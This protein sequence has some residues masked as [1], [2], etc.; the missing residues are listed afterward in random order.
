MA[1]L[2]FNSTHSAVMAFN[3]LRK[4][5]A[6]CVI[7]HMGKKPIHKNWQHDYYTDPEGAEAFKDNNIGFV[8]GVAGHY[9]I[10]IDL[11]CPEAIKLAPSFLS[12]TPWVFGHKSAPRSHYMYRCNDAKTIKFSSPL[13][14]QTEGMVIE[15]RAQG[16]QTVAPGSTHPSDEPVRFETSKWE[17]ELPTQI[18]SVQLESQCNDLAAASLILRHG[19]QAGKRDEVAVALCG[20][21]LR[22]G[23]SV[24]QVDHFLSAIA[25]AAGDEELDMRLKAE[26]QAER[27]ANNEKVPGIPSLIKH[28]GTDLANT[29]VA[30]LG[31]NSL[32][33]IHELNA[34]IA[35]VSMGGKS[36]I[37]IDGG[38]LSNG[39]F[40][41]MN[42]NDARTM[43]ANRG[44]VKLGKRKI[45][46]FDYWI[47]SPERRTYSRL[48][49]NPAGCHESE[50]NF[51]QG[52]PITGINNPAGCKLFLYHVRTV[53][54]DGDEDL[55]DYL[56]NWLADAIQNP[57]RKPGVALVM[58][59][60]EEGTGKTMFARYV[61][62]MFGQYG[63]VSTNSDHLFGKHNFH[64]ARKL[65]VFAD[66]SV[67]AGNHHHKAML[68]NLITGDSLSFEPKGVDSFNLDNHVR[69]MMATNSDWAVP[70]GGLARRFCVTQVSNERLRDWNYFS[71]LEY[72]ELHD[73]PECL[74]H[75]LMTYQLTR[76]LNEVPITGA[77]M[78]NK[79]LTMERDNP[80][81]AWWYQRLK[82]GTSTRHCDRWELIV[83]VKSLY[84][85]YVAYLNRTVPG[86]S[87]ET[88][89][90]INLKR[91]VPAMGICMRRASGIKP[92][93]T[94]AQ[95]SQPRARMRCY[96]VPKLDECRRFF[97]ENIMRGIVEWE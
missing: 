52:W 14:G 15:L 37:I 64:L 61:L 54:C 75:Y 18:E 32:N 12:P 24:D 9:A 10:D 74:F 94:S 22:S 66:E 51:W 5:F 76:N 4:G 23:R 17:K 29:I 46:K 63:S 26:Y 57:T 44:E 73:G 83:P 2:K 84:N 11:D 88:S 47:Q 71:A 82:E 69:L 62:R 7:E 92:V 91:F 50:Y 85:D 3:Y 93:I 95:L 87:D 19:W 1:I 36:R 43:F 8:L 81:Q 68:N 59:S 55:Y 58:Q 16:A 41:T 6:L 25:Q 35:L 96:E 33:V 89:F 30:W 27:L 77:L 53:I 80:M 21:L 20:L 13:K 48:V 45:G 28:M 67:W 31:I 97:A 39:E 90:G 70:A 38:K 78:R 86:R 56:I 34:E 65:M 40:Y 60:P 42:V 79:F 49:F 72:E